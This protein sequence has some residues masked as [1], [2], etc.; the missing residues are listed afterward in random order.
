[1][2]VE[3][4][5]IYSHIYIY[6]YKYTYISTYMYICMHRYKPPFK[7]SVKTELIEHIAI[8][9]YELWEISMSITRE[10][11]YYTENNLCKVLFDR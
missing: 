10:L 2:Y 5:D 4:M 3:Y 6:K 8:Y 9:L 11:N 7:I 1:M